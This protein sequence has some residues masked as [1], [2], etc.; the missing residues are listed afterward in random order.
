MNARLKL[1]AL[2][3]L[4]LAAIP[5]RA[6][7]TAVGSDASPPGSVTAGGSPADWS[8]Y[9]KDFMHD[10]GTLTPVQREALMND[11]DPT[12][13]PGTNTHFMTQWKALTPEQR[14]RLGRWTDHSTAP[15]E[16]PIQAQ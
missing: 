5:A 3:I 14:T 10:W 4:A 8:E 11:S 2:S 13:P 6:A 12:P 9:D 16:M 7:D 15:D 1:L